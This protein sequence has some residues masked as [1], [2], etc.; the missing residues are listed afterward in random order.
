[1]SRM[2]R[3]IALALFVIAGCLGGFFT[4]HALRAADEKPVASSTLRSSKDSQLRARTMTKE[5]LTSILDVQ[6]QQLEENGLQKKEIYRDIQSMASISTNWL[7]V[8]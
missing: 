2:H 3:L 7:I 4:G 6:L 5:L 1:M 8:K